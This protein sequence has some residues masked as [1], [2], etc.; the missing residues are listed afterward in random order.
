METY[1]R[2]ILQHQWQIIKQILQ[3]NELFKLDSEVY[4]AAMGFEDELFNLPNSEPAESP[5][6]NS[7][8]T[9]LTDELYH[10]VC[11]IEG[12][13]YRCASTNLRNIVSQLRAGGADVVNYFHVK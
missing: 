6:D 1:L 4:R 9:K 11:Q 5:I 13:N 3:H 7:S 2:E 12:G 8:S 10:I